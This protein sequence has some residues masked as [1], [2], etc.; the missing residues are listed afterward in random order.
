[1][2]EIEVEQEDLEEA[3]EVI[4]AGKEKKDRILI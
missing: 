3:V 2:E 4:I 1:M